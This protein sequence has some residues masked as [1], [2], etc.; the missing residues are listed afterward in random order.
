M[1]NVITVRLGELAVSDNPDDVLVAM[2]LGSCVGI[3]A[4]DPIVRVAGLLHA[5]L[6]ERNGASTGSDAK[7][8]DTGI[9]RLIAEMEERGADRRRIIIR[10]AGGAEML[11]APGFGNG[12]R[13]GSRNIEAAH[14]AIRQERLRLAGEETGGSAGRTVRLFVGT[15]VMTVRSIGHPEH[16]LPLHGAPGIK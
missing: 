6:P 10:M 8:V 12:L 16:E 14:S 4:Y 7:Y 2:G 1:D 11:I 5:V 3:C 9:Q 13:I 15:G